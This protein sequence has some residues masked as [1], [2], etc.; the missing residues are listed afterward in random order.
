M[1]II[2]IEG[3]GLGRFNFFGVGGVGPAIDLIDKGGHDG[4]ALFHSFEGI[5]ED[6][7]KDARPPNGL[8]EA[9]GAILVAV[10]RT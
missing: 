10:L 4:K 6:L 3:A 1:V 9:D 2:I 5:V 8:I 7:F